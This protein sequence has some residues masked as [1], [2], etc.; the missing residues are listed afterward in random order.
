MTHIVQDVR[1]ALRALRKTPGF[2][3]AAIL[4]L[5]LGSGANTA[6]F[7]IFYQA[8]LRPLPVPAPGQLVNLTS[9]GRKAGR[10]TTS[11]TARAADVFSHPLYRDLERAQSV[12]TGLAAHRDFPANVAYG[13]YAS[14][15]EGRLVSGSYFPVLQLRPAFGRLL[16][17]ADDG[18][19]RA[20]NVVVLSY[21]YWLSRFGGRPSV[22]NETMLVNGH[23]MTVVGVAPPEY[24]GTT[25]ETQSQFYV[26]LSAAALMMSGWNGLDDR[27]DHWLYLFGRLDTGMSRQRAEEVLN[28]SFS[29]MLRDVEL[30]E[31]RALNP[32]ERAEFVRRR[33]ILEPGTQGQRP[34]RNELRTVFTLLFSVTGVVLLIAC[35]NV[36]GLFLVR[37][38]Y[39][40]PETTIRMSLGASRRRLVRHLLIESGVIAMAGALGGLFV[41]VWTLEVLA[42]LVPQTAGYFRVELDVGQFLFAAGLSVGITLLIGA[43]PAIQGTRRLD[44]TSTLRAATTPSGARST[45]RFRT[46]LAT[47]Q[48]ALA[49]GLLVVAA[50]LAKSLLNVGRV[51]LGIEPERLS[52]FRLSPELSGY[53]PERARVLVERV[54]QEIRALPGVQSVSAST[55]P[56]LSGIGGGSNI[57]VEAFGTRIA[58]ERGISRSYVGP[59]YFRTVGIPLLAGREFNVSDRLA[60]PKVAIVNQSFARQFAQGRNPVGIRMAEGR[61]STRRL[62][63][64]VVGVVADARYAQIKEAPPPQYFFPYL[65]NERFGSLNFYVRSSQAAEQIIA[66]IPAAVG[67]VDAALPV[68]NLRTMPNQLTATLGL[69]RLVALLSAA[70]AAMAI[71]LSSVGLYGLLSYI[72]AQRRREIGVRIAL[73]ADRSHI[74]QLVL[75]RVGAMIAVGSLMGVSAGVALGQL[76]RSLLFGVAGQQPLVLAGAAVGTAVIALVAAYLPARRAARLDPLVALRY[77]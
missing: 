28:G 43:Y 40:L 22:V 59:D 19:S 47:T 55:I 71:V 75:A 36:A 46:A 53:T 49:M 10:T 42:S 58:S 62:D 13:G 70:F 52:T 77:E 18:G 9:P 17:P 61:S 39:R 16:G 32:D 7:S 20:G 14:S 27:L 41:A 31:Q 68:E 48:I 25:L 35:A 63:V 5:A 15:D 54:E 12:L 50:L 56:L 38:V 11:G 51:D 65:Q 23:S 72:V 4:T 45:T 6:I 64:E 37:A 33:L 1:Q 8:L 26:P 30:P 69:D 66:M 44:L 2:T 34:E 60:A 73:G 3:A 74:S 24:R 57:S 67:R 76:T 21:G 29:A